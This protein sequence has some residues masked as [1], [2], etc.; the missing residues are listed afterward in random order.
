MRIGVVSVTQDLFEVSM[1]GENYNFRCCMENQT[2]TQINAQ[3][4]DWEELNCHISPTG[5]LIGYYTARRAFKDFTT[6]Q[7]IHTFQLP[8]SGSRPTQITGSFQDASPFK[9]TGVIR[10]F[11]S[12]DERDQFVI[13]LCQERAE[14][15]ASDFVSFVKQ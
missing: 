15:N 5:N 6:R 14:Q 8:L 9:R 2:L 11:R 13:S 7:G 12:E 3:R 4:T 10:L 1:A